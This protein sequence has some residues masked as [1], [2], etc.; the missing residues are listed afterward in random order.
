VNGVFLSFEGPEGSGKSTQ[1]AR[2]AARLERAGLEVVAVREPGGTATGEAIRD[3]LQHDAAGE[4]IGR[5]TETLLFAASRA[6]LV[7]RVIRPAL[8]RGAWVVADRFADSTVAYQGYGRD[9]DLGIVQ[10]I[11]D[12]ATGPSVP[13]LTFLLDIEV[14]AGRE[15]M[16]SRNRTRRARHD[17]I[18]REALPFHR[19]VRAGYLARARSLPGRFRI[20]D[21]RRSETAV[22]GDVWRAVRESFAERLPAGA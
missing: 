3:I 15:R 17:R 20:V 18:E 8:S 21:A 6:Q 7:G 12:F 14:E 10:A 13:D 22:A 1:A 4:P 19:K 11:N 2:L 5:E 9:L 16:G